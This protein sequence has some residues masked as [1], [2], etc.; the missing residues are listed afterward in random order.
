MKNITIKAKLILLFIFIKV[1]PLLLLAY[2]SYEGVIKLDEYLKNSTK[3]LYNQ[4]KEIILNTAN[5][6]IDDSVKN[7]DKKSQLAI[8][9]LSFE[10][11]KNVADFLYERDKDILFLSN[12]PLNKDI[13][14]EFYKSKQREI[15][16][17]ENYYY[18]EKK[19]R[20]ETKKEKER[21]KPQERKAQLKDNEKEFNYTDP[22]ELKRVK[23]PI[24]KEV[25]YFDING[26]EIYK[27]SQIEKKLLDISQK[28][29]TYVNSEDYFKKI[30]DLKKGQIYV[31]NVIGQSVK[32]NI[33][34][35]FTKNKAKKANIAF[36]PQN[37]GYAGKENPN[38]KRFEGII[39]FVTPVYKEDKKVGYVSLALDHEHIMQFTDTV[40]P[41]D[42]N[43]IQDIADA[44]VGNYAFMWDYKGRNIS[45]PRDY[46]IV[47]Y[48]PKTGEQAMPWLS[49]DVAKK[50][51]ASKKD[52]NEFLK[53]Y[54][55][56]EE[57]SLK[58]KPNMRQ[59]IEDGNVG[60]DC[61]YLN[62]APQCQGWM[63]LTQNGGYGSFII[64]WSNIWKLSTAATI[65]YY[66]G[67]YANSKR[68]FGFVTIGANVDEFHAA[69]NKTR[70]DVRKILHEQT[71]NMKEIVDGNNFEIKSFIKSLINELTVI[72]FIMVV[73]VIAIAIWMSNYILSKIDKLLVGTKRFANNELDY[74]IKET[75]ND[76]IGKLEKSF[77]KMASK[78][79][80]LIVEQ[81]ELNEHLEEKV[82]EKTKELTIINAELENRVK[83]EVS[84]NRQKDMHLVQ[85]SKMA[86]I[87]EM[88][89]MIIHQWKQPLNA[90]SMINSGIELRLKLKQNDD[91]ALS[92]D[93]QS[94]KKQINLMSN[95]MS[96][97]R[98]FFKQKD[99]TIY[100]LDE[101]IHKTINLINDIY[102]SLGVS[103]N[104][105][106][107]N[108]DLKTVGYE[109]EL[110]QVLLNVLNNARDIIKEKNC[111]IKR[112]DIDVISMGDDII[113]EVKDYAGGIDKAIIENIFE[114]Y[115]TTKS[116]DKGTG[117]GLY[118]C[119]SILNKVNAEINV[120]N[121]SQTFDNKEYFGANFK[122]IMQNYKG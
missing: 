91:D 15:I 54:P 2:I 110:I 61:R 63:Q 75:S 66:T 23:I 27:V 77:N 3:Y 116:D 122:I 13:L 104:Y 84:N 119:K 7:L 48:D 107:I 36:E 22:K 89:S 69:A 120:E 86:N 41:V 5:A 58:K 9:R 92:K 95:T 98:D 44:S 51:Y 46:S 21:I 82:K 20:W 67:K 65:P 33:I 17:H 37:H 78:I 83:Q 29:N 28:K 1:I 62:F 34:G 56:F 11:A 6:S 102:R 105:N 35:T 68:G 71:V 53:D 12:I 114:P 24:Y 109:N 19:Q 25:S 57:Q 96:D 103:I 99:K 38:G 45:H 90:I 26:K 32:T 85:Q 70:N 31:S 60:L 52:I 87:G 76:E 113:I 18:N 50:Y 81:N 72:T 4:S 79:K 97:F 74:R 106:T 39:R 49:E 42:K 43:P 100:K 59:L 94:I 73:L 108:K 30:K 101:V 80:N 115:F 47:G 16:V 64:Y 88:V 117:L 10:I 8:E 111:E 121:F 112:I 93:N 55:K 118:M 40:N 14:K